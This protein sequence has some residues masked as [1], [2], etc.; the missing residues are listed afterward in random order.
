MD[1]IHQ[2]L[3]PVDEYKMRY[4]D[5]FKDNAKKYF[6]DLVKESK[7]DKALNKT[8]ADNY[9]KKKNELDSLNKLIGKKKGFK[10]L[11]IILAIVSIAASIFMFVT[12]KEPVI[13]KAAQV[14]IGIAGIVLA[15]LF[16]F[17]IIKFSK[18][19]K[20]EEK[21]KDKVEKEAQK[22]QD[23]GYSQLRALNALFDWSIPQ[24]LITSTCPI[25]QMD[26][27]FDA[28]KFQYLHE[29]F[30]LDENTNQDVSTQYVQSGSING[31]PFVIIG[32][33]NKEIIQKTYTGSIVIS[34]TTTTIV[35]GKPQTEHHTQTLVAEIKKPAPHYYGL[36]QLIFGNEAAPNLTFH[37]NPSGAS[38]KSEKE[39]EKMVRSGEKE[40]EAMTRKAINSG[41]SFTKMGNS[42]FD[43]LFQALDRDNE[44]EYRLMFTPLA[45]RNMVKLIKTNEPF[46][47]DFHF[48][49]EKKLNF[50]ISKHSQGFD[51]LAN[52]NT[53]VGF[54][55]EEMEERFI[56]FNCRYFEG[57]YYDLVPLLTIPVY[58]QTKPKEFIYETPY[59][60]NVSG[61][62]QESMA[63]RLDIN[64]LKH[65]LSETKVILKTN[66]DHK[67]GSED[68]VNV[69]AY[70]YRTV[71][72]IEHVSKLGGDGRMHTIPVEWVEYVPLVKDS[73]IAVKEV[74]SSR[75]EFLNYMAKSDFSKYITNYLKN[76]GIIYERGLAS[77]ILKADDI[78]EK[79]EK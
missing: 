47:D 56:K 31:S 58:Q 51:Y 3:E 50:I 71:K 72:H 74:K 57:M 59:K 8:T 18:E 25:I 21:V 66:F 46:G 23:E 26:E 39:I 7:V 44:V 9:K 63:N 60:A 55:L 32:T 11:F 76:S 54:D 35:D 73:Q 43:V 13:N 75:N 64:I 49:K 28:Q 77:A 14:A 52:P 45:Q 36:T 40:L 12:M 69:K 78:K 38:G 42:E 79:G 34:W 10:V 30:G 2:L 16:I 70:S 48:A 67:Q 19:I 53:F 22:Y 4:K 20:S 1:E 17:L 6:D 33:T 24:R 37:R 62:E 5:A 41:K 15:L 29:K 27:H 68:I 61:Y 65:K